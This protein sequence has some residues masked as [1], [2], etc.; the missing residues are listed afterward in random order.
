M[1]L[2]ISIN[3]P[4]TAQTYHVKEKMPL[5]WEWEYSERCS[6]AFLSLKFPKYTKYSRKFIYPLKQLQG[7]VQ[8]YKSINQFYSTIAQ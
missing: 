6:S 1:K 5:V 2:C 8:H 7:R 4:M 3:I